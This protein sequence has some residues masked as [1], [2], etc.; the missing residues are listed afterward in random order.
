VQEQS[1][2]LDAAARPGRPPTSR[3]PLQPPL[4]PPRPSVGAPRE[5][6]PARGNL[7]LHPGCVRESAP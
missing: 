3:R 6:L 5:G 7:D 2:A 1:E 4:Q